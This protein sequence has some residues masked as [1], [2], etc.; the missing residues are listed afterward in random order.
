MRTRSPLWLGGWLLLGLLAV[1]GCP[2]QNRSKGQACLPACRR[3]RPLTRAAACR[4]AAGAPQRYLVARILMCNAPT[5]NSRFCFPSRGSPRD[6]AVLGAA[7]L[8]FTRPSLHTAFSNKRSGPYPLRVCM[9]CVWQLCHAATCF[10]SCP[11][12]IAVAAKILRRLA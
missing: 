6:S 4:Q 3:R 8:G 10:V 7:P 9:S 11:S 2:H 5:I 1:A 12:R